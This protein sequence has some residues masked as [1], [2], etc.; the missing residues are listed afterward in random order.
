MNT[1]LSYEVVLIQVENIQKM[2]F[3]PFGNE[4]LPRSKNIILK[5]HPIIYPSKLK[6]TCEHSFRFLMSSAFMFDKIIMNIIRNK[7]LEYHMEGVDIYFTNIQNN[8]IYM[9]MG[10]LQQFYW[11]KGT[12]ESLDVS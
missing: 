2:I 12:H 7:A 3:L 1:S 8:I 9:Y 10:S 11:K 5:D 4:L 6:D